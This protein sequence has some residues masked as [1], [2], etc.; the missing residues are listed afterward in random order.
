MWKNWQWPDA[1][2]TKGNGFRKTFVWTADM[3]GGGEGCTVENYRD[4]GTGHRV[5]RISDCD[6]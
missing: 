2:R 3:Y 4:L 6:W 1:A 5:K